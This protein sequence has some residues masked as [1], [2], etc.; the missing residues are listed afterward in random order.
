MIL[1]MLR[2]YTVWVGMTSL[3]T[4]DKNISMSPIILQYTENES[5]V[6]QQNTHTQD[7]NLLSFEPKLNK[8]QNITKKQGNNKALK[9]K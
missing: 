6:Y 4:W 7:T 9:D 2:A 3:C 5:K 8:T 1:S